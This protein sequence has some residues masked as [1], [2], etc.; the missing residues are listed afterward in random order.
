M[1][2]D[3]RLL[4]QIAAAL[5]TLAVAVVLYAAVALVIRMPAFALNQVRVSGE[6]AHTTREQVHAIAGELRGTF[7]TLDLEQA[8]AAFEKLP[9]VRR[10]QVR[11]AWPDRLEVALEEHVA[12]ARWHDVGLVNTRGRD[13]AALP[14]VPADAGCG[15][16]RAGR[17]AAER[18]PRVAAA[19]RR[20]AHPGAGS[21]GRGEPPRALRERV[22]AYCPAPA[23]APPHRPALPQRLR[24]ARARPALGRA[25]RVKNPAR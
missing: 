12:L 21:A 17:S 14:A 8:R 15:R 23:R 22:P 4:T 3:H 18:A 19:A 7:F 2:D 11:R 10:A 13:H 1:W 5:F 20:R 6:I 9:W 16:S 24:G 25:R